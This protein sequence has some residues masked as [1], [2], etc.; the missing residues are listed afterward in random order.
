[1]MFFLIAM[2]VLSM[3]ALILIGLLVAVA[4]QDR[5]QAI[6]LQSTD[7][8]YVYATRQETKTRNIKVGVSHA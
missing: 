7:G 1:M 6:A 2:I 8:D 5:R 3:V 4:V